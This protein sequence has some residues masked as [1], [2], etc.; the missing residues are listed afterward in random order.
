M[1]ESRGARRGDPLK[2]MRD[3]GIETA[4]RGSGAAKQAAR[5]AA[6]QYEGA[7]DALLQ[8]ATRPAADFQTVAATTRNLQEAGAEGLGM[9]SQTMTRL[10]EVQA[11]TWRLNRDLLETHAALWSGV[12]ATFASEAPRMAEL[13]HRWAALVRRVNRGSDG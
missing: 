10:I 1:A 7:A 13:A 6:S 4:R 8:A 11:E 12:V 3:V 9:A 5:L 2:K